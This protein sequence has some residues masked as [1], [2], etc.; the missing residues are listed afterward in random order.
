MRRSSPR[1]LRLGAGVVAPYPEPTSETAS[2]VARGNRRTETG[3]EV[4]LRSALHRRGL[5]FRKDWPVRFDGTKVR[6]DI[7]FPAAKVAVFVDG[8]F[9]HGCPEHQRVP[10]SNADYWRRKLARNAE[11][12]RL[13]DAA[14]TEAGWRVERIWE[15]E[16]PCAAARHVQRIV[17]ARR[18]GART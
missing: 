7:V 2:R 1:V 10:R 8:C 6:A 17:T 11:R 12:D 18:S 15:H 9:W 16:E 13:I 4:R 3:P 5:R 14:L